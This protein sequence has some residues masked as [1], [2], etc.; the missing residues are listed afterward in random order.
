[1]TAPGLAETMAAITEART[2]QGVCRHCGGAVPCWSLFGDC[3]PGLSHRTCERLRRWIRNN[4]RRGAL[5]P[6]RRRRARHA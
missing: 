5:P 6:A 1:M 4:R 3:A 2:A